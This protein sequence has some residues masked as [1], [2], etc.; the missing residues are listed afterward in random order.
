MQQPTEQLNSQGGE[1]LESAN[2]IDYEMLVKI[3]PI[4]D[5]TT[6]LVYEMLCELKA[7]VSDLDFQGIKGIAEMTYD[8]AADYREEE[9]LPYTNMNDDPSL[10][11][12]H[13]ISVLAAVAM[14]ADED[15]ESA[16]L[17]SIEDYLKRWP[18]RWLYGSTGVS[19]RSSLERHRRNLQ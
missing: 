5:N 2:R 11:Q 7:D 9:G 3:A 14:K 12:R 6:E 18:T 10:R 16:T 4:S 1:K 13:V 8:T 19:L 17:D 15:K